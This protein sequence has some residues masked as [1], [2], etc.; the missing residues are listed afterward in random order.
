MKLILRQWIPKRIPGRNEQERAARGHKYGAA[1]LK[2]K[3]T[4][5]VRNC[6]ADADPVKP[7]VA[8]TCIWV[9][10]N[11]RRDP[12]NISAAKKYILDGIVAAGVLPNDGW[13]QIAGLSDDF[14]VNKNHPGVAVIIEE[15]N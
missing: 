8:I 7:P 9:E 3:W 2:K 1:S 12:D 15:V 5:Y 4:R 11:K 14:I 6:F 13:K 10:K